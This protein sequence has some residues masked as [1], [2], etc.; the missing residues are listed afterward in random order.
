VTLRDSIR[1]HRLHPD[2]IHTR[3]QKLSNMYNLRILLI[4]CDVTDHQDSIKDLTKACTCLVLLSHHVMPAQ[5]SI[6]HNLTIMLAWTV[7]EAA[8]YLEVYKS[9]E[10][11]GPELIKERIDK[12]Y[13]AQM[14]AVLS[15]VKGI[16][17]TDVVTLTSNFGVRL[18]GFSSPEADHTLQ[19]L[20]RIASASTDELAICPGLGEKKVKRLRDAFTRPFIVEAS[21]RKKSKAQQRG[22]AGAQDLN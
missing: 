8:R 10:R 22:E 15:A 17:K 6:A 19:S 12:D 20:K 21:N 16:N 11:K 4:Q 18:R 14:T 3:I 1:Y 2:Y 7:E 5:T 13:M 9:F